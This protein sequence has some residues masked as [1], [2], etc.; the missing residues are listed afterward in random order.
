MSLTV[1]MYDPTCQDEVGQC[2][3]HFRD[4]SPF[5]YQVQG[6]L[7]STKLALNL[8]LTCRLVHQE[9][10][11]LLFE[12]AQFILATCF[13]PRLRSTRSTPVPFSNIAQR[14]L[15]KVVDL[16]SL[17]AQKYGTPARLLATCIWSRSFTELSFRGFPFCVEVMSFDDIMFIGRLMESSLDHVHETELFA[18]DTHSYTLF[19]NGDLAKIKI[20][21]DNTIAITMSRGY[22]NTERGSRLTALMNTIQDGIKKR[23]KFTNRRAFDI[24]L[25]EAEER[26]CRMS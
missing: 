6:H 11:P 22:Y 17:L 3:C 25:V 8:F 23:P 10:E 20:S 16:R 1:S 24:K 14:H 19:R 26:F 4:D 18:Y 13:K 7:P 21:F 2:Q 15:Q 12:K 5:G 9:A